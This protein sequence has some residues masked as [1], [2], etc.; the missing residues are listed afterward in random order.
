MKFKFAGTL[1]VCLFTSLVMSAANY[2]V[3]IGD[4]RYALD[5]S[6]RKAY[7]MQFIGPTSRKTV[8]IPDN[9]MYEDGK[10]YTVNKIGECAFMESN[11]VTVNMPSTIRE[12]GACAF[13]DCPRF[14]KGKV[15]II[16]EGIQTIGM[17][18]FKGCLMTGVEFPSSLK[19]LDEAAFEGTKIAS[20]KFS[21]L[22]ND[23]TIG[24]FAFE[25]CTSLTEVAIPS[26]TVSLG[27]AAFSGCSALTTV[28]IPATLKKIQTFCFEYCKA[29]TTV[30][31]ASGVT[32]IGTGAFR[33]CVSFKGIIIP[34][35][36]KKLEQQ[37]FQN[38]G[39]VTITLPGSVTNVPWCAFSGCDNLATVNLPSTLK[40]IE[41]GAFFECPSL[42]TIRCD[43][44]TP[45]DCSDEAVFSKES[46]AGAKLIIP[47]ASRSAYSKAEIWKKFKWWLTSGIS[48]PEASDDA[49]EE[50]T[51]VEYYTL[52]GVRVNADNM[53]DGTIYICRTAAGSKLVRK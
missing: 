8:T 20:V 23:L 26:K 52:Q 33:S 48:L 47:E 4:C 25:D 49:L 24:D 46:Y 29:L 19:L 38:T 21:K 18:A 32:T 17:E 15:L 22:K 2:Q 41:S 10:T 44:T 13:Q 6:T 37:A 3:E 9:I 51:G 53:Q 14:S 7:V 1:A 45:P 40:S 36:V 50:L 35:S 16:P 42:L 30:S 27:Y 11:V 28:S 43:A 5:S 34:N 31:L 39:L 12:I